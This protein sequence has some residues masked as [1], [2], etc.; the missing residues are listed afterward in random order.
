MPFL[1]F[2]L[3]PAGVS[4]VH[5]ILTCLAKFNEDVSLEATTTEVG[6]TYLRL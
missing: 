6:A 2:T 4:Q 5:D 3:N 1:F